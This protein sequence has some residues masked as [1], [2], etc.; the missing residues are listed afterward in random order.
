MSALVIGIASLLGA[1]LD[2]AVPSVT[3]KQTNY[4]P[5]PEY[6]SSLKKI[7]LFF[8]DSKNYTDE[9]FFFKTY[10]DLEIITEF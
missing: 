2:L 6:Y 3:N 10:C 7:S 1:C 4:F 9:T 8:L 5:V